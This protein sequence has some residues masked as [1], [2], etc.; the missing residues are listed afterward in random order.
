M[1]F[2][3]KCEKLIVNEGNKLLKCDECPC[4]Y[5]AL[6]AFKTFSINQQTMETNYCNPYIH[7][8]AFE[9]ID[10]K[11]NAGAN[12]RR[13]I[14]VSRT[15]DDKD[16]VGYSKGCF[17]CWED[18]WDWDNEGNCTQREEWCDDCSETWV[19]RMSPCFDKYDDFASWF[20]SGCG[21]SPNEQGKYPDIWDWWYGEKYMTGAAGDCINNH[22]Q[23]LAETKYLVF[24][25]IHYKQDEF[26]VYS[27]S[28]AGPHI[29]TR[30]GQFS[31][32]CFDECPNHDCVYDSDWNCVECEDGSEPVRHCYIDGCERYDY[33]AFLL[34]HE[35]DEERKEVWGTSVGGYSTWENYWKDYWGWVYHSPSCCEVWSKVHDSLASIN[36]YVDDRRKDR[37][38]YNR[39]NEDSII[40]I[41]YGQ[42]WNRQWCMGREYYSYTS[43]WGSYQVYRH[44]KCAEFTIHRADRTDSKATGVKIH[45]YLDRKRGDNNMIEEGPSFDILYNE[46]LEILFGTKFELPFA[47]NMKGFWI[48]PE[49][50]DCDDCN[51]GSTIMY[52]PEYTEGSDVTIEHFN[53]RITVIGYVY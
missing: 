41:P 11:I 49:N 50:S 29:S 39:G 10:N 47:D 17:C 16:I 6:F 37:S 21:T 27:E 5:Y 38:A 34:I 53:F 2:W 24:C 12:C 40:E 52:C 7:V 36:K 42:W 51:W 33:D 1:T 26:R 8:E 23:G 9:V 4:G 44:R 32:Y 30:C 43:S 19:Y 35:S 20:Y 31:Y 14:E 13:C 45:F 22:W 46:E 25:K 28:Y 3:T 15:P 48:S 18:C